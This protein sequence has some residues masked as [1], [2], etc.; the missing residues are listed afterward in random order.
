MR[1]LCIYDRG[2]WVV[3]SYGAGTSYSVHYI[4]TGDAILLNNADEVADF[5]EDMLDLSAFDH[6]AVVDML[7]LYL[8]V[9][10]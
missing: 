6:H 10:E 3:V 4:P 2:G 1:G 7:R 5:R 9:V 8:R